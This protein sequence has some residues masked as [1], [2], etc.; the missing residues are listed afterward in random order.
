MALSANR[1]LDRYVDQELRSYPVAGSTHIYKGGFITLDG[2]GYAEA[3]AAGN[4]FLGI[5]Y[6][7]ADNSSGSDGDIRV[8]VFTLGDFGHTLTGATVADVGRAVFA[9]AD[10]TLT[11]TPGG[12]TFVGYVKDWVT[13]NQ[14]VLRLDTTAPA[15][16]APLEH[17]AANFTLTAAHSGT[18]HTNLGASG[19]ITAT[20]PAAPPTGTEF[21]FVCMA[22]Q[23]LRMEPGASGG[24]YIKGAKQA[25]N[26]YVSVTDIGDFVH[27]IA[28][29][30]GDWV[31]VA[32]INGAD[33]DITVE[34]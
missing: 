2:D 1:E 20:L 16:F 23:A 11:F 18:V 4:R 7:E 32:S 26:K 25:D 30:N 29:G 21:K 19:T 10:N 12:N 24:I 27:L 5:A 22:D 3:L 8:R 17:H 13:T 28:D 31:A 14:I 34:A 9:D 15:G 33:A 6:E